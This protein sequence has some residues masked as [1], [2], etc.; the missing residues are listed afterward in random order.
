[1]AQQLRA[2]A[3][4]S[5]DLA[6]FLAPTRWLTTIYNS[7]SRTLHSL[8]SLLQHPPH[9]HERTRMLTGKTTIYTKRGGG[10]EHNEALAGDGESSVR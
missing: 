5:E 3:A 9:P 8:L 1:M 10:K 6:Q 7:S 2:L 4:L